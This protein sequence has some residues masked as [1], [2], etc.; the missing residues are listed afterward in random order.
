[1]HVLKNVCLVHRLLDNHSPSPLPC[2]PTP[3][4][5]GD[6]TMAG[7]AI[8][9]PKAC[10]RAYPTQEKAGLLFVWLDTSKEG[11]AASMV[12]QPYVPP[13]MEGSPFVW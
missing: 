3:A 9:T 11:L 2:L 8:A 5:I 4:Q 13:E 7:K 10:A 6:A 12:Q 1:M